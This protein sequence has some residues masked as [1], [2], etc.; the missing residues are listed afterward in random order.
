MRRLIGSGAK[1]DS[2]DPPIA[3]GLA[4]EHI[5]RHHS[6]AVFSGQDQR[7]QEVVAG[8]GGLEIFDIPRPV[9]RGILLAHHGH[10]YFRCGEHFPDAGRR[11]G[12]RRLAVV[13]LE[14]F[15][16]RRDHRLHAGDVVLG[17]S[18]LGAERSGQHGD[19]K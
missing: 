4:P 12:K 1:G 15:H 2:H 5:A 7:L 16:L 13:V 17:R 18:I 3:P 14:G 6:H 8:A 10:E 9:H 19:A 11:E